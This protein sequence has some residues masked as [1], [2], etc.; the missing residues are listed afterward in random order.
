MGWLRSV[1]FR[2]AWPIKLR[3]RFTLEPSITAF[4]V[5]NNA[6]F[7]TSVNSLSGILQLSAIGLQR[8]EYPLTT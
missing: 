6:N 4:N 2:F 5:F 7:D 1:D 3:E 8:R